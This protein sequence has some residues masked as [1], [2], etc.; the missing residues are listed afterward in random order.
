MNGPNLPNETHFPV[1][2]YGTKSRILQSMNLSLSYLDRENHA[3]SGLS[4]DITEDVQVSACDC[5]MNLE[6]SHFFHY[7]LLIPLGAISALSFVLSLQLQRCTALYIQILRTAYRVC[8]ICAALRC[9]IQVRHMRTSHI[10]L[11]VRLLINLQISEVFF[12][13]RYVETLICSSRGSVRA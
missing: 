10:T 3:R 13:L 5:T 9:A 12:M 11:P 2:S 7:I 8:F 1:D 4:R 6:A